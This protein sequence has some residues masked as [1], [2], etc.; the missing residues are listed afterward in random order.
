MPNWKKVL[1]NG[2]DGSLS[3]L[4]LTGLSA[5]NSE[6]DVLTINGSNVVGTRQLGSNACTSTTIPTN[7]NQL[8]NGAGYLTSV[9]TIN[10]ASGVTG[11]LPVGNGGTGLTSLTATYIPYGNGTSA[12]GSNAALAFNETNKQLILTG[13]NS[14]GNS[15]LSLVSLQTGAESDVTALFIDSSDHVVKKGLGTLAFENSLTFASLTSK[16]TTIAGYG[17]TDSLQIGTTSTTALA[18]NTTV[19]TVVTGNGGGSGDTLSQISIGGTTFTVTTGTGNGTVDTSGTSV[20]NDFAKFTDG[21]T[22]EGRSISETK[23]DLSLNN[24][25]NTALSTYTGNGGA[26][27]NQYIANNAGYTTNTG[28]LTT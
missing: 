15:P 25:E 9:G 7:N 19:G 8:S 4:S 12:F 28:T 26:L 13:I 24:V 5:Q 18:G 2:N 11:T 20:D 6:T 22:I 14:A 10:L 21:N 1:L 23:S 3:T 16:P 17:I 27:D